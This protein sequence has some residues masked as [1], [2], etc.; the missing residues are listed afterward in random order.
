MDVYPAIDIIGGRVVRLTEGDYSTERVYAQDPAE[1]ARAFAAQGARFL[2]A[3]DLDGARE[4]APRNLGA[5]EALCR[6][7]GL[8]VEAGGGAR[9]EASV[10]RLLEAG[11]GRVILGS[12]A[13]KDFPL[14]E[15]LVAKHGA[16]VA[17]GVDARDGKVAIH[18]W[19]DVTGEDA[20]AFCAKLR[21]AGVRCVIF[22]DIA[23]DGRLSGPNLEAYRALAQ[24]APLDIVAS[25]GVTTEDDLRGLCAT[26]VSACI[27]GKSLYEGRVSLARALEIAA[28]E[29]AASI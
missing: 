18:G 1:Q 2:H 19:R 25:G 13:V 6:V 9:D 12:A 21:D 4:G 29:T 8:F 10:E 11:V 28:V 23:R 15:R 22:T 24:L 27:I 14:V 5:I 17:V 7:P 16:R 3:V 20:F 26:G